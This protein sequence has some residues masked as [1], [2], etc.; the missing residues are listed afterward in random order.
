MGIPAPPGNSVHLGPLDLRVYGLMYA[1]GITLAIVMTKR[2]W[3]AAGGHPALVDEVAMWGVPTGLIGARLY[4]DVTTPKYIPPH[5]WGPLAIWDGGLG[6]WGGIAV[7]AVVGVWRVR[8]SGADVGRFM[9]AVAPS[10]LIASGIGRIGNYFN[11]ELF[12]G[13]TRLPWALHVDPAY[14]PTGYS[15]YA[16]FHPTFAYELVFDITLA[17]ALV[18][19][20]HHRRIKAPGL[21]ALYVTGYSGFRVFEETLRVD[22]SQYFLGLRLNFYVASAMTILGAVWFL[23]TQRGALRRR[24]HRAGAAAAGLVVLGLGATAGCSQHAE[25]NHASGVLRQTHGQSTPFWDV[26]SP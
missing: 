13:P 3:H 20:G 1:V 9:D 12:G 11:Q 22:P 5:W 4:F 8:R 7:A 2:R 24:A 14:R 18:W 16:T 19:L 17:G 25:H 26:K 23:Y 21:F 15:Q 10:L 6:I